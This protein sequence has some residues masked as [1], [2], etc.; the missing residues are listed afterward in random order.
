MKKKLKSLGI[1]LIKDMAIRI[2]VISMITVMIVLS[3]KMYIGS[4]DTVN[5]IDSTNVEPI[6]YPEYEDDNYPEMVRDLE[7]GWEETFIPVS[8]SREEWYEEDSVRFKPVYRIIK[9]SDGTYDVSQ[10]HRLDTSNGMIQLV[11]A[12]EMVEDS[13]S[14]EYIESNYEY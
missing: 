5:I 2:V 3:T 6:V 1:W 9:L 4:R 8:S 11:P 7:P 12:Y 13:D 10:V 14:F